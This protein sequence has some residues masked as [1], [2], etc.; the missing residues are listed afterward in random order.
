MRECRVH[1]AGAG[2]KPE[3]ARSL[4]SPVSETG[5]GATFRFAKHCGRCTLPTIH[6]KTGK[7]SKEL[8]PLRTLKKYRTNFYPHLDRNEG[9]PVAFLGVNVSFGGSARE[10]QEIRVGDVVSPTE[11]MM[12]PEMLLGRDNPWGEKYF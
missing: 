11:T 7:R 12:A 8:E 10:V 9:G 1:R 6:R 3:G 2:L 4:P 5:N